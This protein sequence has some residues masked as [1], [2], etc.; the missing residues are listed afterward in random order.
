M[1]RYEQLLELAAIKTDDCTIWPYG[2][3]GDEYGGI[4]VE[5]V[6]R[7][8]H[9]IIC[10]LS[11]G[12]PFD[13]AEAAHSCGIRLCINPRHTRWATSQENS[14]D[15]LDHDT[16]IRGERQHLSKLTEQEVLRI[17]ALAAS[18]GYPWIVLARMFGVHSKSINN[19]V[20]RKTWRHI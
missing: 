11:H 3:A 16:I 10:E 7:Y 4:S 19:I 6:S 20:T 2:K 9:R 5:G 18:N 14:A 15:A 1:N 12:M 8:C 17:R 13:G